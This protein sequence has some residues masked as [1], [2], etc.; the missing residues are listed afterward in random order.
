MFGVINPLLPI[1]RLCSP[2][3]AIVT[4]SGSDASGECH[5]RTANGG[6]TSDGR[7]ILAQV[8]AVT[9]NYT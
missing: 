1:H 8:F 6:K 5:T 2:V 3:I 7:N 4:L 9:N